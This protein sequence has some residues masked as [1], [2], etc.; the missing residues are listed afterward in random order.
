MEPTNEPKIG[1][2]S[3][4]A[5]HDWFKEWGPMRLDQWVMVIGILHRAG[6][7]DGAAKMDT[8]D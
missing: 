1:F 6:D 2:K 5:P 7:I 4:A 8:E 3:T